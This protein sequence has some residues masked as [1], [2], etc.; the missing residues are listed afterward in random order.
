M[1][2]KRDTIRKD[3]VIG[4]PAFPVNNFFDYLMMVAIAAMFILAPWKAIEL[5]IWVYGHI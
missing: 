1:E 5:V 4:Q 2:T 3:F